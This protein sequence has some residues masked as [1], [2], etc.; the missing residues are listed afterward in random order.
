[1][2]YEV[3]TGYRLLRGE[4][5]LI[6]GTHEDILVYVMTALFLSRFLV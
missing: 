3:I 5:E 2:L 1:M 6:M 4:I